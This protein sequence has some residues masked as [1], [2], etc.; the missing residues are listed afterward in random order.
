[1]GPGGNYLIGWN[2][3]A[4]EWELQASHKLG[5]EVL[6]EQLHAVQGEDLALITCIGEGA[7]MVD[8]KEAKV[9]IRSSTVFRKRDGVWK[10][11]SH[12]TDKLPYLKPAS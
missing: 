2:D 5:G 12:Q 8:G 4:A 6:P 3:I 11:I 9:S 1:M 10:A 7:N